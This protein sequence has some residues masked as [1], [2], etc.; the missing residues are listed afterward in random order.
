MKIKSS[1][2][3]S[4]AAVT[5]PALIRDGH[6]YILLSVE[7]AAEEGELELTLRI[8][9]ALMQDDQGNVNHQR[10]SHLLKTAGAIAAKE[11]DD[12]IIG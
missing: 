8:G 5:F 6:S 4:F 10:V 12:N 1:I 2:D 3:P 11:D 7:E 9:G